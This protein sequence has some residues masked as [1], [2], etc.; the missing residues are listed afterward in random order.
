MSTS[1]QRP[2]AQLYSFGL[3]ETLPTFFLP[4]PQAGETVAVDMQCVFEGV[5]ERASYDARIDDAQPL[6]SP[7]LSIED[8]KWVAELLG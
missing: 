7:S 1:E 3:R 8:R 2:V 4:L 5:I 6:Q